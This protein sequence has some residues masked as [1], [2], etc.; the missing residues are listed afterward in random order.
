MVTMVVAVTG[1]ITVI[2]VKLVDAWLIIVEV[3]TTGATAVVFKTP[4]KN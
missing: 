2:T 4:V 1:V 3:I